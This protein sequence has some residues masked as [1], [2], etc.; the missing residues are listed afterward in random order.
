MVASC[1]LILIG[2]ESSKVIKPSGDVAVSLDAAKKRGVISVFLSNTLSLTLP[3]AG[4]GFNWQIAFH[5]MR[6]LKQQTDF[7]PPKTPD[8]GPTVTFLAVNMGSTRL[9]FVLVP[10][11]SEASVTP[12]DQQE[13]AV[14]I[15]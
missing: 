9:R 8:A 7:R 15:Q 2:C 14:K 5:D 4:P 13:V 3:P 11:S 12:I 10:V 6:F 1:V